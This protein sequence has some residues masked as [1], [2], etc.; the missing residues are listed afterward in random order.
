MAVCKVGHYSAIFVFVECLKVSMWLRITVAMV[1]SFL[2]P[3]FVWVFV[4]VRVCLNSSASSLFD[5]LLV[6]DYEW[7]VATVPPHL[8]AFICIS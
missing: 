4:L 8:C 7:D 3:F 5:V 1:C 2:F 6:P